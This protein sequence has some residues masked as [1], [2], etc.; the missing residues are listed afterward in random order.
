MGNAPF[1]WGPKEQAAFDELKHLIASEE[2]TAQPCPIGKFHLEVDASGYAL[3]GVLSQLQDDKWHS[4]VFILHT[5]MDAELN[6]DIYD[7]ELLAIMYMLKERCPYLLNA[8][9]TFEFWTDH[10]NL[11]YFRKAPDLNSCQACWYLKLQDFDYML[12]HIPGTS[13]SKADILSRLPWYKEQTPQKTA[14]TML[15]DKHF[16]N[17]IGSKIV[18]F[19]E[20]QFCERGAPLVNSIKSTDIQSNIQDKIQND[21]RREALVTKLRKKKPTLFREEDKLL[22]YED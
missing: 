17:K 3:G 6:Y 19:Q 4:V 2:V 7:K 8:H 1:E 10:K 15:P 16:I 12:H 21:H 14:V 13:N 9:E 5:M 22:Y 20:Q 18:L 11:L